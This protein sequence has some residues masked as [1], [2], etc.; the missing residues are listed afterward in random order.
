MNIEDTL[1]EMNEFGMRPRQF[2]SYSFGD[3]PQC[4]EIIKK[5]II[6]CDKTVVDFEFLPE[7]EQIS[8][9]MTNTMG[10]GLFLMGD[11]GRGKTNIMFYSIP[12]IFFHFNRKIVNRVYA[13]DLRGELSKLKKKKFIAVDDMGR[14]TV[15]NDFGV[16][17]E[18]INSL[19]SMAEN[20]SK[21]LFVSTNL[22]VEQI[23]ERYGI[24]TFDRI[25]RLCKIV[26]FQGDSL[27]K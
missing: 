20:E 18:P 21:I 22:S 4:R 23:L 15:S 9:W 8:Q 7:Y 5:A 3:L 2:L 19:F 26:K 27:R 24:R 13:K 12:L 1:N 11:V 17:S 10:K 14:E 16:K 6:S 25:K